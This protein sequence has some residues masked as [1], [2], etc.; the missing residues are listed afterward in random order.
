MSDFYYQA[1]S[2][3][4][5]ISLLLLFVSIVR[6][7]AFGLVEF[8]VLFAWFWAYF[9]PVLIEYCSGSINLDL[10]FWDADYYAYGA[11]FTFMALPLFQ[12]GALL[13]YGKIAERELSVNQRLESRLETKKTIQDLA[14]FSAFVFFGI[15]ILIVLA[16]GPKILPWNRSGALSVELPGFTIVY[17]I[18]SIL[19][20]LG[21]VSSVFLLFIEGKTK[22]L[23]YLLLF[24]AFFLLIGR[25]GRIVM[26]IMFSC[27]IITYCL[28]NDRVFGNIRKVKFSYILIFAVVVFV[29]FYGKSFVYSYFSE[30]LS[31]R[32]GDANSLCSVV[33]KGHQEYDLLWP[34]VIETED[35]FSVLMLP[36]ST[37]ASF[38]P[39]KTRLLEY[40]E[41]YSSTDRLM[42]EYNW[43]GYFHMKFGVSPNMVQFYFLYFGTG[44]IVVFIILG[45]FSR[46]LERKVLKKFLMGKV[47]FS[48]FL[49]LVVA[50]MQSAFDFFG[51]YLLVQMVFLWISYILFRLF[52]KAKSVRLL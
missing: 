37:L 52:L 31:S 19:G 12:L 22:Y 47:F 42:T 50:L 6:Y 23:W 5:T 32:G 29:V 33:K 17:Q 8:Y 2:I 35:S 27:F 44:G 26:P 18:V 48:L 45:Y 10:Y 1:L 14:K 7:R 46:L 41:F 28:F 13:Y 39:H 21:I 9:R 16:Y 38:I 36:L 11:Y 49:Y 20:F 34:A 3:S 40:Q 24:V 30:G 4:F 25:R 51:K 15:S 43:D